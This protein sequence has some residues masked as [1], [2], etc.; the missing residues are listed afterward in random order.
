MNS[1]CK[2]YCSFSRPSKKEFLLAGGGGST[3]KTDLLLSILFTS[4]TKLNLIEDESS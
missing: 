3:T 1:P 2:Q 4:S